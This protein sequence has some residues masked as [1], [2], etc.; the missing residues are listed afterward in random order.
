[1][2][3]ILAVTFLFFFG[4][5][6]FIK[7][8]IRIHCIVN[9]LFMSLCLIDVNYSLVL[10]FGLYVYDL[11]FH[12]CNTFEYIHNIINILIFGI[13]YYISYYNI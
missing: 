3:E 10:I 6:Y 8:W 11:L 9:V 13:T 1:M 5:H 12:P 7:D 2:F 4:L